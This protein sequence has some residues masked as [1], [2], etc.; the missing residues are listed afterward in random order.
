MVLEEVSDGSTQK[1]FKRITDPS[2]SSFRLLRLL[3][4]GVQPLPRQDYSSGMAL[5]D[6]TSPKWVS[7][8]VDHK[9]NP[10][11]SLQRHLCLGMIVDGI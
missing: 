6:I 1:K 2:L 8:H 9:V 3:E 11:I 10:S 7:G 5:V 4:F